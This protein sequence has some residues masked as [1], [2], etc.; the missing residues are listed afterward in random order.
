[1]CHILWVTPYY[2]PEM[3]A[4]QTRISETATRLVRRGHRVTVLTTLPNYPTGI[5]PVEYRGGRR[6]HE[7]LD[8]VDVVRVWSYVS[9][10]RG[11]FRRVVAQL[12][13][14]SL[15]G[16]FGSRT[17]GRPDVIIVESPPLFDA[18]AGRIL[19]R[20]KRAPYIFTV[21]DIWPESAVQ[22]GA[23]HNRLAIWLAERV[24]WSTYRGAAAVWAVTN[25]IRQT[26]LKRGL[27]GDRVFALPNG[28]DV[29]KFTPMDK[30]A[31]R[32]ELGWGDE[33]T[34]LYAGTIGLSHGLATVLDAADRLRA[35]RD[36][37]IILMGDG[38]AKAAL[39]AEA[40]QRG[41]ANV[42]FVEAQPHERMPL[43]IS[44]S[45]ACLVSLRKVPLFE[46]ALPSKIY[47]AMACA[48]PILLAVDG[49]AR[50]LIV[51]E[52]GAAF[53]VPQEDAEALAQAILAL[54]AQPSLAT[55]MGRRGR[56]LVVSRFDRDKLT[57][58]LEEHIAAVLRHGSIPVNA[59]DVPI[60][61]EQH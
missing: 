36:I 53:H 55:E 27:P 54:R 45:D 49:E 43:V 39:V 2:P 61:A 3:G 5:V 26:L 18:F 51:N 15:A 1:M 23:L 60:L 58:Q 12:S 47:E 6:R 16:L 21:A 25:G 11:F 57:S 8:G 59:P 34:V 35:H 14:G 4:A 7:V 30:F 37:R 13:F 46:G 56:T 52:T 32:A 42:T 24:E 40:R 31:A 20:W 44:A 10:N 17:V 38:A 22:L 48:R 28:A 9:A 19:A 29:R 41:M 50:Q 33:F